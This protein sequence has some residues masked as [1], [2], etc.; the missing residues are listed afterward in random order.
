V[1]E[2]VNCRCVRIALQARNHGKGATIGEIA[3]EKQIAAVDEVKDLVL[4]VSFKLYAEFDGMAAVNPAD[5]VSVLPG[6][7]RAAF[8]GPDTYCR[9]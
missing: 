5:A 7:G 6:I 8:A 9:C 4:L 1:G 2:I 3:R